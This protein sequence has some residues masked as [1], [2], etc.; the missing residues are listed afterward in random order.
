MKISG[1]LPCQICELLIKVGGDGA[2]IGAGSSEA[3]QV[4]EPVSA[5]Q[6]IQSVRHGA[7]TASSLR[8]VS[9]KP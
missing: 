9:D 7:A 6:W 1:Q 5:V 4:T 2:E 3:A 8:N